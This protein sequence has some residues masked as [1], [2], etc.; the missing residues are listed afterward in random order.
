MCVSA[1]AAV[2]NAVRRNRA[3]RLLRAGMDALLPGIVPGS[4]LL[5]IARPPLA[6]SNADQARSA[7]A[8]LLKKAGLL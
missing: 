4:D 1:G 3:K 7:L 2:G 6:R 8:G 5:L